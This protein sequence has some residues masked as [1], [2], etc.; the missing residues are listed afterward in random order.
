MIPPIETI[1][2]RTEARVDVIKAFEW[3]EDKRPGLGEEFEEEVDA[4]LKRVVESPET[5]AVAFAGMRRIMTRRFPFIIYYRVET[6]KVIIFGVFHGHRDQ[7]EI[8][9]RAD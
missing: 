7:S 6:P 1:E 5:Y 9:T 8:E 2:F 3:Y 4:A